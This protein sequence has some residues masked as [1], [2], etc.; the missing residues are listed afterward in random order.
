MRAK[1]MG[2]QP[3][4]G[5]WQ[6]VDRAMRLYL[7]W[8]RVIKQQ[9]N[10]ILTHRLSGMRTTPVYELREG[11]PGGE[12]THEA[13][14]ILID[15]DF[16][17]QKI[18]AGTKYREDLEE[19]VRLAAEGDPAKV[20]FIERYWL[21]TTNLGVS[22]RKRLVIE[23]L[24]F[25]AHQEWGTGRVTKP[26]RNFYIWRAKLYDALGELLGYRGEE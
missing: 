8:E 22:G 2:R 10:I 13:E 21:T 23:A 17:G 3:N 26:N 24:P 25:L 7:S 4:P 9:E 5:W 11:S 12:T 19:T 14:R 18:A 16:A 15:I 20:T 6:D 1:K